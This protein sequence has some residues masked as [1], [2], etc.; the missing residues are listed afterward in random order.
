GMA[1]LQFGVDGDESNTHHPARHRQHLVVYAGTHDTDTAVGWAASLDPGAAD[2]ACAQLGTDR[3]GLPDALIH[4]TL[5][6]P[7]EVAIALAQDLLGLGSDA[8][9]NRPG[10]WG[11]NWVFRL[12]ALPSSEQWARWSERLAATGRRQTV[13]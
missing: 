12:G 9:V 11:G 7:G 5:G 4:A 3:A 2:R 8:R 10:T 1:V 13:P 6:S